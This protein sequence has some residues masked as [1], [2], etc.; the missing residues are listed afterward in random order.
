MLL[1]DFQI[2]SRN[3]LRHTRRNLFLGGALAATT[4]LLVLLN[5]LADGMKESLLESATT[6]MTGHVNVGGFYKITSSTAAPLVTDYEKVLAE[7]KKHVAEL[8]Y[9]TVRV[10]GYAKA[11]SEK[12]SMDLVL[13][14]VDVAHEPGLRRI[15]QRVDGRLDDLQG[16]GTLMLFEGQAERLEVRVGD[17][18]TL[19]APT[20]RGQSNTAV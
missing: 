18:G 12:S 14:G 8:D 15:L 10:R 5:G 1:V 16:P 9:Y 11:V 4:A 13:G 20:S 7:A 2:A 6:L 19:V 3:L 17:M